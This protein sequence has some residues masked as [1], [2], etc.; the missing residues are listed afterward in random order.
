MYYQEPEPQ[1]HDSPRT[2]QGYK[3]LS[4]FLINS[5]RCSPKVLT[6]LPRDSSK[7]EETTYESDRVKK[8]LVDYREA[9]MDR[10]RATNS[11]R[12]YQPNLQMS[13]N[14]IFRRKAPMKMRRL[15]Y[16]AD[17]M[18]DQR[19]Y[20]STY[21]KFPKKKNNYHILEKL[22]NSTINALQNRYNSLSIST[23]QKERGYII[24][25]GPITPSGEEFG[26]ST[27][28]NSEKIKK[29]KWARVQESNHAKTRTGDLRK[30]DFGDTTNTSF[31]QTA[32]SQ[33]AASALGHK[34]FPTAAMYNKTTIKK[35]QNFYNNDNHQKF[36]YKF[37]K[38]TPIDPKKT[39]EVFNHKFKD[40]IS[41]RQTFFNK[42]AQSEP[43]KFRPKELRSRATVMLTGWEQAI[44]SFP[45][46]E[47][48]T[49]YFVTIFFH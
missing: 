25:S 4:P 33:K 1:S 5:K 7:M 17:C 36:L 18:I 30:M 10:K 21:H 48:H 44:A 23:D 49:E 14:D 26:V 46:H 38:P 22:E 8:M 42:M 35:I 31:L 34:Q 29:G 32:E 11:T 27:R 9:E 19:L 45:S 13:S 15:D 6:L 28:Y 3:I 16:S 20:T 40:Q 2:G 12:N 37:K 24:K 39:S 41:P 43:I 47:I